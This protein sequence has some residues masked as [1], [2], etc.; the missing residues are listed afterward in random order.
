MF[1]RPDQ[2]EIDFSQFL[3]E[4]EGFASWNI[5]VS[6]YFGNHNQLELPDVEIQQ[7]P[8]GKPRLKDEAVIPFI[9]SKT[10]LNA[11]RVKTMLFVDLKA[12]EPT[13]NGM[14]LDEFSPPDF[15]VLK[16]K[17]EQFCMT[18]FMN[19]LLQKQ[20]PVFDPYWQCV[21]ATHYK[22]IFMGSC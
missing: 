15:I 14:F 12:L 18:C 2:T 4:G 1:Q 17:P 3:L 11:D 21:W 9:A 10:G 22:Y 16:N 6:L 8:E 19:S 7:T 20:I 13:L 5:K